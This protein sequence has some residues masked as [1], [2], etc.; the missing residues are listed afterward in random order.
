MDLCGPISVVGYKGYWEV[1]VRI[2]YFGAPE[3]FTGRRV[4]I[5]LEVVHPK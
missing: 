1:V 3:N 5:L 2:L 4:Y